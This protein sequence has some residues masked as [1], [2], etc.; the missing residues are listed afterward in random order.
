MRY[1]N[2]RPLLAGL[3][4]GLPA[5]FPY[6]FST[7]EPSVCAD[8]LASGAAAAALV[9]VAALPTLIKARSLRTLGV[10]C[11][12]QVTSVLLVTRVAPERIRRL[13]VHA[14]SQTS[15]VLAQLLLTE[16]WRARATAIRA[17]PPLKNMLAQADAAVLIG[18][19][20]LS[21]FGRT[22][23]EEIDLAL[24]WREWTGLPFVFAVWATLGGAPAGIER[25]LEESFVHAEERWDTLLPV[26]SAAHRQPLP[27]VRE[28][29]G[30]RLHFRLDGEDVSAVGEFLRRAAAAGLLPAL[31]GD[32]TLW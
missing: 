30:E 11:R 23:Y 14:A 13:A 1:L 3:E 22:G 25:L 24:A 17:A 21:V 26:W 15:A 31:G 20:A 18:D 8:Q 32:G 19:P 28:Y 29:L 6:R 2:S 16:R 27:R 12:G 5:P 4:A 9:P 10:A 7:A